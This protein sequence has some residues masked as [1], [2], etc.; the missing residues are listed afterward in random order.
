[1]QTEARVVLNEKEKKFSQSLC[2]T[3]CVLSE[4]ALGMI[5]A[6]RK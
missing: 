5:S 3:L 2:I 1:M 4:L 6:K